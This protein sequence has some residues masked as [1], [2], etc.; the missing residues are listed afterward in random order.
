MN[1]K[2][3]IERYIAAWSN[4]RTCYVLGGE[5]ENSYIVSI[6]FNEPADRFIRIPIDLNDS[7]YKILHEVEQKYLLELL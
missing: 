1:T 3:Y 5:K 7:I 4:V 6:R 2:R